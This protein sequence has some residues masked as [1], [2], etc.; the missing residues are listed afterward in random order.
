[1]DLESLVEQLAAPEPAVREAAADALVEAGAAA[2]GP[3]LAAVVDDD[4]PVSVPSRVVLQG[5][6]DPAFWP[7]VGVLAEPE[8]STFAA[9][10][11]FQYLEVSDS[12]VYLSVLHHPAGTVRW[13]AVAALERLGAD[14]VRHVPALVRLVDDPDERVQGS[15]ERAFAAFGP[16]VVPALQAIRRAPGPH[17]HRALTALAELGGWDAL[18]EADRSLIRRLI[19]IKIPREVPEPMHVCGAWFAVRTADQAAVLDAFGL[20]DPMPVT[21]RLGGSA[22]NYDHHVA[23]DGPGRRVYVSPVLDGWTLVFGDPSEGAMGLAADAS[24]DDCAAALSARFGTAHWYGEMCGE[25]WTAWCLAEDGTIVRSFDAEEPEKQVGAPHPAEAGYLLPHEDGVPDG[26]FEGISAGDGAAVAATY[27]QL[28]AEMRA[29]DIPFAS[30]VAARA[31]VDPSALGPHTS[32]EGHGV[33]ALT[34]RGRR[35]GSP[36]GALFI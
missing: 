30:E 31:S 26:V 27:R 15:V 20:S 28:Q 23:D 12:A 36:A 2:I 14:G 7:L 9:S 5:I 16:G 25:G 21:M 22:W 13:N 6:G 18:E 10:M 24:R 33:L 32:V 3:L 11:A 29:V 8:T 4:S 35:D 1:V 34:D 19:R 17:R